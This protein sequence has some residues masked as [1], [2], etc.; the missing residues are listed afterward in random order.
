MSTRDQPKVKWDQLIVAYGVTTIGAWIFGFLLFEGQF[1]STTGLIYKLNMWTPTL[2]VLLASIIWPR[3]WRTML[4]DLLPKRDACD[5]LP[6]CGPTDADRSGIVTEFVAGS[7]MP[8]AGPA[9]D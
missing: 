8:P 1:D 2:G 5:P 3:I 6:G 9:Y 4:T 7:F